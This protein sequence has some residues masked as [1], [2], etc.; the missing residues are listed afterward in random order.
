I[1]VRS[2]DSGS[3]VR[4]RQAAHVRGKRGMNSSERLTTLLELPRESLETPEVISSIRTILEQDEDALQHY[5]RWCAFEV[6]LHRAL[7]GEEVNQSSIVSQV[8]RQQRQSTI[9]FWV[10]SL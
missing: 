7:G 4:M 8:R 5:V 6:G 2:E 3:S 9:W 10:G 1:Q